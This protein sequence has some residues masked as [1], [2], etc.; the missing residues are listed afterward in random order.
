M[1]KFYVRIHYVS[2]DDVELVCGTGTRTLSLV[3]GPPSVP[4]R[5][6]LFHVTLLLWREPN[7]KARILLHSHHQP[8][9]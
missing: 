9:C 5:L 7:P 3:S 4:L 1:V 2:I 6:S 8:P